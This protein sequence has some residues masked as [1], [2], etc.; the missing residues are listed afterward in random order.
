MSQMR[1]RLEQKSF[2]SNIGKAISKAGY[3][4]TGTSGRLIRWIP[5]KFEPP[6]KMPISEDEQE[7]EATNKHNEE[8][9]DAEGKD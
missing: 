3:T 9:A 5:P 8:Y 2:E 6:I 4:K 1:D 7:K